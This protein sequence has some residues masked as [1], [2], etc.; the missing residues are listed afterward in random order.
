MLVDDFGA[1]SHHKRHVDCNH[2]TRNGSLPVDF[3]IKVPLK[4][5]ESLD[6]EFDGSCSDVLPEVASLLEP[7]LFRQLPIVLGIETHQVVVEHRIS[8]LD[9]VVE[10]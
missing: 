6:L 5:L 2:L 1:R 3:S 8:D 9:E 4:L 10:A 7:K